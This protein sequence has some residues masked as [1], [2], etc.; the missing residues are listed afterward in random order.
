[1]YKC[2]RCKEEKKFETYDKL[3]RHVGMVHKVNSVDFHVEQRLNGVWPTCKCGCKGKVRWSYDLKGFREFCQGHQSRVHNNWGHN[4][5]AIERSAKTRRQQY[6][7]GARKPW[8]DGLTIRDERVKKNV[9]VLIDFTRTPEERIVRSK[10]MRKG[11]LSGT[12]P[13]QHGPDHPN[14]KGGVSE[15]NVLARARTRLYKE[16]KYPILTR[17]GFKCTECGETKDLQVHHDKERMC[18]IIERHMVDGMDPQTFEE[19][20]F[21]A[22]AVVDYHIKNKVS[23]VTICRGCHGKI[24]PSLNFV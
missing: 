24:H 20:E 15:I 22:D 11:R 6:A 3:R 5:K 4:S 23:G 8:N 16:W 21:I 17:D 1:M 10:R 9:G 7:S 2:N 19:K 13:T 14:W 18:E 12:V